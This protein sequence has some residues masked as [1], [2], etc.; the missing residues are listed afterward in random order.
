MSTL[1]LQPTVFSILRDL[2]EERCGLHYGPEDREL[3]ADRISPR[4]TEAGFDSLLDYYYFLRYDPASAAEFAELVEALVVNETYLFREL[5]PVEALVDRVIAPRVSGGGLR[6]ARIWSAACATGEE[7][8]TLAMV[9]A[10][11]DLLDKVE[12][13]ASDISQRALERARQG[14][15]SLRALRNPVPEAYQSYVRVEKGVV[16]VREDLRVRIRWERVNLVDRAEMAALGAF[17]AILCRNVLIYFSDETAQVV[18]GNLAGRLS[19]DGVL[20]VGTS[21]S[22]LRFGTRLRCEERGGVFFYMRGEA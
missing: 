12:L 16:S 11:R 19:E 6:R 20:L 22:L 3:L 18:V 4:A 13:V 21:E 14:R 9:L 8:L 10:S 17:D 15:L 2:I 5:A 1:P 7:P